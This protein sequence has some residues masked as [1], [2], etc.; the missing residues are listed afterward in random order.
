MAGWPD[1]KQCL[2]GYVQW[3]ATTAKESG[4]L[5]IDLNALSANRLDALGQ[6]GAAALFNDN[7]HT[8]KAGA[9]LNAEAVVEGIKTLQECPLKNDLLPAA[10]STSAPAK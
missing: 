3:A 4:A 9:K 8:R 7:Q 10:I 5:Y 1:C 2:F 6:Q